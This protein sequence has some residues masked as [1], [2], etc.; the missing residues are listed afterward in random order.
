MQYFFIFI[1]MKK[2]YFIGIC[3]VSMSALALM[4]KDG[5][6]AVRGYDVQAKKCLQEQGIAVDN[7]INLANIDW[8]DEVIFSSAFDENFKLIEYA[9]AQ[10]KVVMAR[11]EFLAQI[12]K[13]YEKVI[14]VAGSHGK[15]TV[16]AMIYNILKVA[17]KSPSLHNGANLIE[18]KK[19]YDIGAK[20]YFV[21]E[22]CEYHD[23]FLFL[24][25]YLGVVTNIEREH[26][27]YFK[28]FSRE[29]KSYQ[30]F[31]ENCENCVCESL[32]KVKN[33]KHRSPFA[34]SFS[35][36]QK[37]A[38]PINIKMRIGGLHNAFN[39]AI[40][41]SAAK[42]LGICDCFIKIGLQSFMGL[43]RRFERVCSDKSE[44]VI[45]D[46]A[47]HPKQI[48]A[49]FQ[50]VKALPQKK[51]AVFQPHTFSRTKFFMQD[52]VRSLEKFDEIIL[53]KTFA[54]RE[55]N[56][57]KVEVDFVQ[58]LCQR[59][60]A[61]MFYDADALCDKLKSLSQSVICIMGAGNLPDLL[62]QRNFICTDV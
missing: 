15:S 57:C 6:N 11:G 43:N 48:D 25:P 4:A 20:Q 32:F 5:G 16:T 23:N 52:F 36:T 33:I 7:Q 55:Q 35:L 51:V 31:I 27:D 56:D 26:L 21:T 54:A 40:A 30:K 62:K 3:G 59:K 53:F 47:H 44:L 12:A 50:S 2:Y 42:K 49:V 10:K 8:A 22:A 13:G 46:Y 14:A 38:K 34:I 37:H 58:M 18:T 29:K 61:V 17:G 28:T 19:N 39:A 45:V 24:R 41:A 1:F 9:K 60:Q